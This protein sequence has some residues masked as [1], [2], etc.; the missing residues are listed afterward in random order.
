VIG[1]VLRRMKNDQSGSR[2][3]DQNLGDVTAMVV[4]PAHPFLL[5]VALELEKDARR[6]IEVK[7]GKEPGGE[8]SGKERTGYDALIESYH[9][10]IAYRDRI[11]PQEVRLVIAA[12]REH[13]EAARIVTN[14][15]V[16]WVH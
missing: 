1:R 8:G 16:R 3:L 11:I 15:F 6:A 5:H 10:A 14:S 9:A 4:M 13:P 12:L 7:V 2:Y